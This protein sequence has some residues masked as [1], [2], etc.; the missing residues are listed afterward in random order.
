MERLFASPADSSLRVLSAIMQAVEEKHL[1]L[2]FRDETLEG[3]LK[4]LGWAGEIPPEQQGLLAIN[5][6]N[7]GGHKSDQFVEQDVDV[8]YDVRADGDVD[9]VL[10]IRRTHHGPE[11]AGTYPYPPTENPSQKNN[12]VYQ[13]VLV[14]AGAELVAA[15][16]FAAQAD[17]PLYVVP[18]NQTQL[19]V[20]S[21][22][23]EWQRGQTRHAS[24]TMIG[25]EAGYTFFAN[26][27]VTRPGAS[28]V[29]SYHYRLPQHAAWPTSLDPAERFEVYYFKQPGDMR[30]TIRIMLR[31]P[32]PARIVHHVSPEGAARPSGRELTWQGE[33]RRDVLLGAVFEVD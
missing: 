18:D 11:E 1:L 9:V 29:T 30:T 13:R 28:T 25:T 22:V 2:Y 21:D 32:E 10:T 6:A 19:V 4:E 26:W 3:R 8:R 12:V 16:G 17:I 15:S 33:A 31:L 24:G 23:A 27:I 14:P 20:D 7:I 5:N